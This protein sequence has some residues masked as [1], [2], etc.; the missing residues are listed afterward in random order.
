M[1]T[2]LDSA[3]GRLSYCYVCVKAFLFYF[4]C[5]PSPIHYCR[6]VFAILGHASFHKLTSFSPA[7]RR[8]HCNSSE[9]LPCRIKNK[10]GVRI[11]IS[12]FP[13][14]YGIAAGID[15]I[16][17]TVVYCLHPRSVRTHKKKQI[18]KC[19]FTQRFLKIRYFYRKISKFVAK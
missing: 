9:S 18:T 3:V 11:C 6:F 10:Y 8:E 16:P 4:S 7:L 19:T 15:T 12:L 5:L 13:G 14:F 17:C 2:R 1:H